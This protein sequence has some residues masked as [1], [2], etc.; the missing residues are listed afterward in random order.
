MQTQYL[1]DQRALTAQ[2][3]VALPQ[4]A[5]LQSLP[6]LIANRRAMLSLGGSPIRT[7]NQRARGGN[8]LRALQKNWSRGCQRACVSFFR[9]APLSS[10][11][12]AAAQNLTKSS[13]PTHRWFPQSRSSKAN[14]ATNP[15]GLV[16]A[17][18]AVSAKRTAQIGGATC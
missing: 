5:E 1:A 10:W 14:T 4:S 3:D 8:L 9:F 11:Q 18:F 2:A 13:I 12:L 17:V 15:V 7:N 16:G 6:C